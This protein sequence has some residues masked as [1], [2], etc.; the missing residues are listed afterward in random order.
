MEDNR[1]VTNFFYWFIGSIF[2]FSFI[3]ILLSGHRFI[4]KYLFI[5]AILFVLIFGG[6]SIFNLVVI[7][8]FI[9]LASLMGGKI[10]RGK[11]LRELIK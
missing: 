7:T 1:K 10:D 6:I 4:L 11:K 3:A 8:P 9:W 5:A 2:I